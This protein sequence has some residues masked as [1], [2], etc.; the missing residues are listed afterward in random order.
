MRGRNRTALLAAQIAA[1]IPTGGVS[2]VALS[3]GADPGE[4]WGAPIVVRS[5]GWR[6]FG[7]RRAW[8]RRTR[9]FNHHMRCKSRK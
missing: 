9:K 6:A 2:E 5:D 8:R 7:K 4:P 3:R 1:M